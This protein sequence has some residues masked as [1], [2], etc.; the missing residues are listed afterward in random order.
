MFLNLSGGSPFR[1]PTNSR[2]FASSCPHFLFW[3]QNPPFLKKQCSFKLDILRDQAL[4]VEAHCVKRQGQIR[5]HTERSSCGKSNVGIVS[6]PWVREMI[7]PTDICVCFPMMK[8]YAHI[9]V[10]RNIA[11][12]APGVINSCQFTLALSCRAANWALSWHLVVISIF[13]V[14]I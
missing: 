10:F 7:G 9:S 13:V 6:I 4:A 1:C 12:K 11:L 8:D 14:K 3:T 2:H 5:H